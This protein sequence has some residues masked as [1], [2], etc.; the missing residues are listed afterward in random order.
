MIGIDHGEGRFGVGIMRNQWVKVRA[1]LGLVDACD[2]QRIS[3]ISPKSIDCLGG[4]GD[5]LPLRKAVRC[6]FQDLW[7][8]GLAKGHGSVQ[9][10]LERGT[11]REE[12][13][14]KRGAGSDRKK[15]AKK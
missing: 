9:G 7:A 5:E 1:A 10:R 14:G 4:E 11:G 13:E 15:R 12:R 3:S 2:G 6:A 8:A